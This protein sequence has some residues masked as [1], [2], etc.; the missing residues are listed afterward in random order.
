MGTYSRV[1]RSGDKR[2]GAKARADLY[3]TF[4]GLKAAATPKIHDLWPPGPGSRSEK[5]LLDVEARLELE[6][7]PADY[8]WPRRVRYRGEVLRPQQMSTPA[9]RTGGVDAESAEV[10]VHRSVDD[11]LVRR[12]NQQNIQVRRASRR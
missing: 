2:P 8:G 7:E 9:I 10:S 12:R 5:V 6:D 1:N 4:R 11:S 3:A